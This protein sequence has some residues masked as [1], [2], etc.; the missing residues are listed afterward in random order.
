MWMGKER[1]A[2]SVCHWVLFCAARVT[3]YS[4]SLSLSCVLCLCCCN[5][6]FPCSLSLHRS[7]SVFLPSS[8]QGSP[9]RR[10]GSFSLS[11][12][13]SLTLLFSRSHSFSHSLTG[14]LT[15]SFSPP[16]PTPHSLFLSLP[17]DCDGPQ[18]PAQ[19]CVMCVIRGL[20][21]VATLRYNLNMRFLQGSSSFSLAFFQS[22]SRFWLCACV[23]GVQSL[24]FDTRV[25]EI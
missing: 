3:L 13:L 20:K 8:K 9:V 12:S 5:L 14:P 18:R 10:G 25:R 21:F 19:M 7:F 15:L 17:C 1:R 22:K 6:N 16:N 2:V 24:L 4:L 23:W 11:F